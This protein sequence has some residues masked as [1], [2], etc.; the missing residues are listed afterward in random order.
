MAW[1]DEARFSISAPSSPLFD[2]KVRWSQHKT[3][4]PRHR[5][6]SHAH[7]ATST[8][9][10]FLQSSQHL[11]TPVVCTVRASR[12]PEA[13]DCR[14][15]YCVSD[16][17][18]VSVIHSSRPAFQFCTYL[19]LFFTA[20][21]PT[22]PPTQSDA[23]SMDLPRVACVNVTS[24]RRACQNNMSRKVSTSALIFLLPRASY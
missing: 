7:S 21:L 8:L 15:L 9:S 23:R 18:N 17:C 5:H 4:P 22:I 11:Q 24:E 13:W 1:R 6:P 12:S 10:P 14:P 20:P 3:R 16:H 19:C 2:S